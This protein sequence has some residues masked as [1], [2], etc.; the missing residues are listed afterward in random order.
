MKKLLTTTCLFVVT[1]IAIVSFIAPFVNAQETKQAEREAMYYRYRESWS[2]IKG[3]SV[4]PHWM[5]D[6]SSF[7]YAEDAPGNT[8]IWKV[9]PEANTKTPLLDTARLRK[10][11]TE[12]VGH[13][14][15]YQGLPFAE[16]TF[17]DG[18]KAVRFRLKDRE[19]ILNLRTY[20]TT[21][22]PVLSQEEDRK[23]TRLNSSHIQKSRM[24]S[25]A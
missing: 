25:S 19:F 15:S 12:A 10:A 24:P 13:E 17:V 7:W 3:G 20:T 18:E 8:V 23:S 16:F 1:T 22:A 11:L 2:R 4:E 6:G 21:P 14:P 9:D 5:A